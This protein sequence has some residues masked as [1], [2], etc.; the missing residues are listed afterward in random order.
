MNI[1][2]FGPPGAGKGTQS[3]FLV[4]EF[5]MKHISTGDLFRAAIKGQT[6]L[7][8][9]AKSFMDKGQLVPDDV[10]IG[11]VREAL[12]ALGGQSFILDGF[13]RNVVQAQALDEL[14]AELKLSMG[15]A[16]FL[17]VPEEVLV[18]RLSGRRTCKNCGAVYHLES[19]PPKAAGVCDQCGGAELLQRDD[20]KP[21]AIRT[22]LNIYAETT[23]PLKDYYKSKGKLAE[24][25]GTG[26]V[27]GVYKRIKALLTA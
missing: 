7:G 12:A 25:D 15:K 20:D 16:I 14:L 17:Q 27:V 3:A 4:E 10:T 18:G 1:L 21:E 2:L 11:M 23:M 9:K 19:K 6:P 13:P 8:V 26:E 24:V 5:R 22:R